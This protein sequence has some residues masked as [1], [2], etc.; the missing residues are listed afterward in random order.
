MTCCNVLYSKSEWKKWA[1]GQ[2]FIRKEI[3]CYRI[4]TLLIP[5]S[6]SDKLATA[7]SV[8]FFTVWILSEK[9]DDSGIPFSKEA[10]FTL[11]LAAKLANQNSPLELSNRYPTL[12]LVFLWQQ[13]NKEEKSLKGSRDSIRSPSVKIQIMGGKVCLR[14]KSK[15]LLGVVNKLL[16]TKSLLTSPN[17]VWPYYLM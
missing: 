3:T 17:N 5:K 10:R 2:S 13:L 4:G 7:P 14:C 6:I 9:A 11:L 15:T 12:I 16:A 1:I 8:S